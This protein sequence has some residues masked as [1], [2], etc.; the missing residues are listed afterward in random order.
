MNKGRAGKVKNIC[1]PLIKFE[2]LAFLL[3]GRRNRAHAPQRFLPP[4]PRR[5]F[6]AAEIRY[7]TRLRGKYFF[8]W[9]YMDQKK[10][11]SENF[12]PLRVAIKFR[13]N[14]T[15]LLFY[16]FAKS[17]LICLL[18]AFCC[19]GVG[20]VGFPPGGTIRPK[21]MLSHS[22]TRTAELCDQTTGRW[23]GYDV[24]NIVQ[25]GRASEV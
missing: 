14:T 9:L 6:R 21:S 18:K 1:Y 8:H 15:W 24:G 12:K 4:R 7:L 10:L 25:K 5:Y 2:F 11:V 16:L 19:L 23:V 22:V 3:T 13:A 17:F 20:E